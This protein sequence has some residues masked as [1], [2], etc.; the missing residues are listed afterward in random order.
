MRILIIGGSRVGSKSFG[1]WLSLETGIIYDMEPFSEN[2]FNEVICLEKKKQIVKIHS[3]EYELVKN[4]HWDKIIGLTR[5]DIRECA[6]SLTYAFSTNSDHLYLF[7]GNKWHNRYILSKTWIDENQE[8]INFRMG[9][10]EKEQ[11][12]I[13]TNKNEELQVTYE[14]IFDTKEDIERIREY[15]GVEKFKHLYVIDKKNRYRNN[16][17]ALI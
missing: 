3:E 13:L 2:R 10:I 9:I 15:L 16:K 6:I 1:D 17:R 4:L 11:N 8:Q 12:R 14:G 5:S 7:N